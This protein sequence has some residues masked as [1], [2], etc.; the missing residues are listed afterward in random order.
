MNPTIKKAILFAVGAYSL[1]K[2]KVSDFVSELEKEGALNTDDGEAIVKEF[3]K[4]SE[5]RTREFSSMVEKEVRRVMAEMNAKGEMM[6]P[7]S[8]KHN[9]KCGKDC[10]NPGDCDCGEDCD[11]EDCKK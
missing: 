5:A 8:D 11:C 4:M 9:C 7:E 1:T 10:E 6:K 2:E 3:L